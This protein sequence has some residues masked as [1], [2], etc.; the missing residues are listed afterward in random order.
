MP[1]HFEEWWGYG[2]FFLV[3]A[4]AQALYAPLVLRRPNR[5]VLLLGVGGNLAIALFTF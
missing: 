5:M 3:S 2:A 4:L 1:E